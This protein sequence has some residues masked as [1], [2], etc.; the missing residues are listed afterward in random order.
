MTQPFG[1]IPLFRELQ[2]ILASSE[3]PVNFEIARQ[4]AGTLATQTSDPT[5]PPEA[6]RTVAEG[7]REAEALLTGYTRLSLDEPLRSTTMGRA[8]WVLAVLDG[9]RWLLERVAERFTQGFSGLGPEAQDPASAPIAQMMGQVAPLMLGI[10]TGTVVGHLANDALTRHDPPIPLDDDGTLFFVTSNIAELAQDYDFDLATFQRWLALHETARQIVIASTPWVG[11][12]FRGLLTSLVDS[13][14]IDASD[15]ERRLMD[16]QSGGP[17]ALTSGAGFD[18]LIPI[19]AT[20]RHERALAG[21]RSFLAVFEGYA[22]AAA[23]AVKPSLLGD[24]S[25]IDEGMARHRAAPSEGKA[26]LA[27]VLGIERDR[28]LESAGQTFCAAIVELRGIAALNR[29]WE[30]PDNL[31]NLAEIKDP[32]VW[33]ERVLDADE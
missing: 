28:A 24:T 12:Y 2:R 11:R 6:T 19:A 25:R 32:F 16:L 17:E 7:V 27:G 23:A 5:P 13:I 1:D 14:E 26:M 30:A 10:Q 9:W 33:I 18:Q 15:M 3:G 31:P 29:V 8:T 21:L 22:A 20:E 4:I